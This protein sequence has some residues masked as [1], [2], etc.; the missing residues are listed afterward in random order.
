MPLVVDPDLQV[1]VCVCGGDE[2]AVSLRETKYLDSSPTDVGFGRQ[3]N[4]GAPPR[5]DP[6]PFL[7]TPTTITLRYASSISLSLIERTSWYYMMLK[8]HMFR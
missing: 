7:S 1:S 3:N 6:G 4:R 5:G 2:R 8:Q